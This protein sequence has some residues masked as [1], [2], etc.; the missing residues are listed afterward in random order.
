MRELPEGDHVHA[1]LG[2]GAWFAAAFGTHRAFAFLVCHF[3]AERKDECCSAALVM[4]LLQSPAAYHGVLLCWAPS[5]PA[6]WWSAPDRLRS[7]VLGALRPSVSG[8][9][10]TLAASGAAFAA[11]LVC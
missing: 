8:S 4:P 6:S 1:T 11:V 7:G 3:C 9:S 5:G 2:N 10:E